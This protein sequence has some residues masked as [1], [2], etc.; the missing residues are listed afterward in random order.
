MSNGENGLNANTSSS[1]TNSAANSSFNQESG[2]KKDKNV[3]N[4]HQ[5]KGNK[6]YGFCKSGYL[7][8]KSEGKMKMK[9]WQKRKCEINGFDSETSSSFLHIYHSDESKQP[10]KVNLLTCQVKTIPDDKCSFDLV[11]YSRTYHFQAEDELDAESW[12]SVILNCKEAVLKKEF[13]NNKSTK[14]QMIS[15]EDYVLTETVNELRKNIISSILKLPGNHGCVDCNSTKDATWLSCNMGILVCIECSGIHRE[16]G[17]HISRIF[18][19]NLDNIGISLLLLAKNMSNHSF[20]LVY[21]ANLDPNEKIN[22]S[23]S[24]EERCLFIKSKYL[25]RKFVNHLSGDNEILKQSLEHAILNKNIY[26]V[27]QCH[28]ENSQSINWSLPSQQNSKDNALHL[29]INHE[30][31]SSLHLV[32]FLI[33]NSA[34]INYQNADGNTSL[35]LCILKNKSEVLKLLLRSSANINIQNKEEKTPLQLVRFE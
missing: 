9:V 12:I 21:E 16:L 22:S 3:Y 1:S 4:L 27:L 5:L 8:K 26:Q 30:D 35:H 34:N 6:H 2:S 15:A 23:S 7:H 13:D 18:S 31:N 10:V 24:M 14:N 28:A 32:D 17:V 11:S 25:K 20:N 19:L 33:Q 29:A